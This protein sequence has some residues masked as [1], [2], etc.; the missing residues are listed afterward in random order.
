MADS[1]GYLAAICKRDQEEYPQITP[2]TQIFIP[3]SEIEICVIGVICGYS[4]GLKKLST[5][6]NSA[7]ANHMRR[8]SAHTIFLTLKILLFHYRFSVTVAAEVGVVIRG[9]I[10][11]N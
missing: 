1:L 9:M 3:K 7:S 11:T 5:A 4:Y 2:I 6:S 8:S 10:P